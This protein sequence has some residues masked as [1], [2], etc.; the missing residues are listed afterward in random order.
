MQ[1]K[2]RALMVGMIF[3]GPMLNSLIS[4]NLNGLFMWKDGTRVYKK[5]CV[6]S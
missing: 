3:C 2:W 4:R 1:L 6:Q 5:W